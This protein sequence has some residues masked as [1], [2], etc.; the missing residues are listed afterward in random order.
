MSMA[1]SLFNLQSATSQTALTEA[2]SSAVI[3]GLASYVMPRAVKEA[4][5]PAKSKSQ[6]A[7]KDAAYSGAAALINNGTSIGYYLP[8]SVMVA[9][10]VPVKALSEGLV[11]AGISMVRG[12][13]QRT[14]KSALMNFAVGTVVASIS[15]K[16]VVP[17][18]AG[19]NVAS[20]VGALSMPTPSNPSMT[21]TPGFAS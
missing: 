12:P 6:R 13:K 1:P 19:T 21:S 4:E 8:A 20:S 5:G 18:F 10:P 7:M 2:A 15:Q 17:Y 9:S 11:F 14:L 16:I 3:G